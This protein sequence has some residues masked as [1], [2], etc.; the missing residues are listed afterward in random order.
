MGVFVMTQIEPRQSE[1]LAHYQ[2]VAAEYNARAN[3]TCE[4]SY[5]RLVGRFLRGRRR[6]LELGGGSSDLLETLGCPTAVA[7][8]LSREMLVRRPQG[9][10]SYRV[11]AVGER[12]PFGDSLFDGVFSINVLEHIVDLEQVLVESVR[13]LADEGLWLAVTPNGNWERLLDLAERW[14]LKIPEGPHRF[15]TCRVLGQEVGRHLEILEHRTNLMLPAGP[16]ALSSLVDSVS[17][18][19]LWGGG[20]FQYIVARKRACARTA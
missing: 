12:L 1:V 3:R 20:F 6:L 15:L 14:S 17:L 11:V 2:E 9:E 7:C 10:G 13:V 8:D 5:R 16:P 19:S 18:C 4:L